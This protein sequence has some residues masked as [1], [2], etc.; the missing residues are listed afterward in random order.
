M[1]KFTT[2]Q[3]KMIVEAD[4]RRIFG[5]AQSIAVRINDH[6]VKLVKKGPP[7]WIY[8]DGVDGST[9][10][11]RTPSVAIRLTASDNPEQ[12]LAKTSREVAIIERLRQKG[13]Q[14]QEFLGEP[15]LIDG[16]VA[17][18]S[19]YLPGETT[20]YA[21]YGEAVAS[22][23]NAGADAELVALLPR[24]QPLAEARLSLEY[25]EHLDQAG[26]SFKVGQTVFPQELLATFHYH[27]E[28]GEQAVNEMLRISDEKGYPL[29]ILQHDIHLG[30]VRDDHEGKAMLIDLDWITAGVAEA[31]L[32]RPLAQWCQRFQDPKEHVEA[33]MIGYETKAKR[34]LD[35]ELLKLAI[36]VADVR[37]ST[38]FITLSIQAAQTGYSFDESMFAQGMSRLQNLHDPNFVWRP[39]VI[40]PDGI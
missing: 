17:T 24:F 33:F 26:T 2:A 29:T 1:T 30:N 13:A 39:R 4:E 10:T 37:F 3:N 15:E 23:H 9:E 5:V 6:P 34:K 25:L 27:L 14:V 35:P 31:D 11:G 38:I 22:L 28:Q 19:K 36:Q 16:L 12:L 20:N 18:V 21:A 40:G 32:G 7:S 8:L